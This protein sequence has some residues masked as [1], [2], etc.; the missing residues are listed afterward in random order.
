MTNTQKLPA[1][2]RHIDKEKASDT[3][4][5]LAKYT[6]PKCLPDTDAAGFHSLLCAAG[7]IPPDSP[8]P[9]KKEEV[10]CFQVITVYKCGYLCQMCDYSSRNRNRLETDE[11]ILLAYAMQGW[12]CYQC[13]KKEGLLP[14][15]FHAV[16]LL[17]DMPAGKTVPVLPLF[18]LAYSYI[19]RMGSPALKFS[20]LPVMIAG[21]LD[22]NNP[23]KLLPQNIQ[24]IKEYLRRLQA[25]NNSIKQEKVTEILLRV[26]HPEQDSASQTQEPE[27]EPA[28]FHSPDIN[29]EPETTAECIDG[30]LASPPSV[31]LSGR[32]A[33]KPPAAGLKTADAEHHSPGPVVPDSEEHECTEPSQ[34][35]DDSPSAPSDDIP[36]AG[37]PAQE[38]G[39]FLPVVFSVHDS[40]RTGFPFHAIEEN[41]A[42]FQLLEYFLQYNPLLGIEIVKDADNGTIMALL[43]ASNQF[44]YVPADSEHAIELFR[45]FFSKSS[46]R[47]QICMDPYRLYC[48]LQKNDICCQNVYSLRSAYRVMS[49][50]KGRP[51]M[52]EPVDMIRELVSKDN[53]YSYSPYIFSML[54][55]VRMYEVLSSHDLML[56]PPQMKRFNTLSSIDRLLGISYVLSDVAD[57]TET[58]FELDEN[59]KYQFRYSFGTK[60]KE[61]I[62]AIRFTFSA[63]K[64]ID[65]L[66]TELLCCIS[67]KRLAQTYGLRLLSYSQDSFIFA[68]PKMH[69]AQLTDAIVN[70]T[71]VLAKKMNLIPVDIREEI[72]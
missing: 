47:R 65:M 44:F 61:G 29:K 62:S 55:Y 7:I 3:L 50:A 26:L 11:S 18:R 57:T 10:T 54:H 63:D 33:K 49:E 9:Q 72:L 42:D 43:C 30:L 21:A 68:I 52:K 71:A 69:H 46:V 51:G 14:E 23:G 64:P 8:L 60:M 28:M 1:C 32:P 53:I 27:K 20:D 34:G 59:L 24:T 16:F 58:L 66:V 35:A 48:F 4:Y 67:R 2:S 31:P 22:Q 37:S 41:P 70:L 19:E 45:A 17:N 36:S 56:M 39:L 38:E 25:G 6:A 40:E 5:T 15:H 13:L 12:N